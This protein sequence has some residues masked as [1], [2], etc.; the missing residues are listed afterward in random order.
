MTIKVALL[1]N[2][3]SQTSVPMLWANSLNKSSSNQS[4]IRL[5]SFL[6]GMKQ[7]NKLFDYDIIQCH[8]QKSAIIMYFLSIVLRKRNR[9][10]FVSQGSYYF[11]SKVNKVIQSMI[12]KFFDHIVFVN[13]ELFNQLEEYQKQILK[14]KHSVVFNAIERL[15]PSK[16]DEIFE[17]YSINSEIWRNL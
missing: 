3:K 5:F 14:E 10:V 15:E 9:F 11:L 7:I 6:E 12:Y 1:I 17:K 16:D 13:F 8:H 4:H 2:S